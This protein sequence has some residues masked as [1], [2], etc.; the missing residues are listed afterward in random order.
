[1]KQPKLQ[2][3]HSL[4]FHTRGTYSRG[5]EALARLHAGVYA[6]VSGGVYDSGA[7]GV[8]TYDVDLIDDQ[9]R[10]LNVRGYRTPLRA[11]TCD[12]VTCF[13]LHV[14]QSKRGQ[15]RVKRARQVAG[16]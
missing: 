10:A 9:S 14:Q 15:I 13:M 7:D 4:I 3:F 12:D 5:C 16:K 1:M 8:N 11:V 2:T 6:R